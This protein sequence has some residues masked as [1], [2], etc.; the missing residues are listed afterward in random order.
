IKSR[1]LV[2]MQIYSF[3]LYVGSTDSGIYKSK[4]LRIPNQMTQTIANNFREMSSLHQLPRY[5]SRP[6]VMMLGS[7]GYF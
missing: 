1:N 7:K 4:K 2:F 6:N 5:C 3:L